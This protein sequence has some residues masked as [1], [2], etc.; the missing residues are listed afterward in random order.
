MHLNVKVLMMHLPIP[1]FINSLAQTRICL[2]Y[3]E[4]RALPSTSDLGESKFWEFLKI[5]LF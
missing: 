2:M 3:F 1:Y 4:G 5:K